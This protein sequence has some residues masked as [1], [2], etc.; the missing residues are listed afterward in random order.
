MSRR[1][2]KRFQEPFFPGVDIH[3][4]N[5]YADGVDLRYDPVNSQEK[6]MSLWRWAPWIEPV[7]PEHRVSLGEGDTPL[8]R[9]RRLGPQAGLTHLYFKL[10]MVN[11][12][13]SYKDRFAA[14]AISHMLAQG[15]RVCLATSSG[16]TGASLAAYCAAAGLPCH[17]AL[18]DSAPPDKLAQM[19]A[20]GA[21]LYRVQGFGSDPQVTEAV[22]Q[23]IQEAGQASQAAAQV[24]AYSQS[25]AGMTGVQT[26]S[27]ELAEQ[28]P[29]GIDHVFSQAGG[30]GLTLAT[31]RGFTLLHQQG[32]LSRCPAVECVQPAGND[33]IATPLRTGADRARAVACTTRISGLQVPS[34]IDGH[35]VIAACRQVGGTGHVVVDEEVWEVQTRLAREEGIF[36]EPAAVV[37]IAGALKAAREGYVRPDAV[38]VCL[39]T[40][41]GFKDRASVERMTQNQQCPLID[42]EE[43]KRRLLASVG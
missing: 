18:V 14:V 36:C 31:T 22:V 16:N 17:V 20:Y 8:L 35:E 30:G 2:K 42:H 38:V 33:T 11:P 12:T 10:D 3:Q 24:S 4:A 28:L 5:D 37:P 7:P 13:G 29:E 23:H 1:L 6:S 43:L 19:Q 40:G 27:Y 26:I 25:P 32:K 15:K 39:L 21:I 9:S 41:F 34:V